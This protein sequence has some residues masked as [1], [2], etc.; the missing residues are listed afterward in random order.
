M[1]FNYFISAIIVGLGAYFYLSF[2]EKRIYA[3][4]WKMMVLSLVFLAEINN[5]VDVT[6]NSEKPLM[7]LTLIATI[8]CLEIIDVFI[9]MATD[10]KQ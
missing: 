10:Q 7:L 6:K 4:A 9:D 8:Y 5:L 3:L 1:N 2:K